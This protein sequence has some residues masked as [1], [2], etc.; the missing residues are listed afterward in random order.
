[1]GE[2]IASEAV[3]LIDDGTLSGKPGST[4]FDGEG[5]PTTRTVLL[6]GGKVQS[7]LNDLKYAKKDGV[8]PTGNAV[9][10]PGSIPEAGLSN[11]YLEGGSGS[12]RSFL[13]TPQKRLFIT[14]LMGVHTIDPVSGDYSLGAKGALYKSGELVQPVSGVTV[15]GNLLELLMKI[16]AV[17]DDLRFF[18]DMGG[19]SVVIEDVP[20]AGS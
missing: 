7:F 4:P 12:A 11:L 6:S 19:C 17:G 13:E 10:S 5:V 15:A 14:D 1:M 2:K 20:V 16:V 18:G 8:T 9:R 3:T